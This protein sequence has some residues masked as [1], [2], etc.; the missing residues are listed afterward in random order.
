[1]GRGRRTEPRPGW[2]RP[3]ADPQGPAN[4]VVGG[5]SAP[6]LF[7]QGWMAAPERKASGLKPLPQ[8]TSGPVAPAVHPLNPAA[9]PDSPRLVRWNLQP[10]H[11]TR[12]RTRANGHHYVASS[13]IQL[14]FNWPKA[15]PS[16]CRH[17]HRPSRSLQCPRP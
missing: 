10:H 17:S 14:S 12:G 9:A 11:N 15:V 7:G 8:Q 1:M 13:N 16:G 2:S 6:R 3:V 5:A 4:A